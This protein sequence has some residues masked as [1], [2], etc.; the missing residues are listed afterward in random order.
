MPR[1][2]REPKAKLEAKAAVKPT[3]Y[4]EGA[5]PPPEPYGGADQQVLKEIEL[6]KTEICALE[7][8]VAK[9][10]NLIHRLIDL[11]MVEVEGVA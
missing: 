6:L 3:F 10:T 1:K 4:Q 5:L 2:P 7:V 9:I 11:V 8:A